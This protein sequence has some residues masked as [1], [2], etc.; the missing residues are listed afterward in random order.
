VRNALRRLFIRLVDAIMDEPPKALPRVFRVSVEELENFTVED[1]KKETAYNQAELD[2]AKA[3]AALRAK[4]EVASRK[5]RPLN[6]DA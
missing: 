3:A 5:R 6:G 2:K 1:A 4:L